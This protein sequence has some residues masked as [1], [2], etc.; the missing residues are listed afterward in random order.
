LVHMLQGGA[1]CRSGLALPEGRV[2]ARELI[3]SG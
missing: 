3:V 2:F 1:K